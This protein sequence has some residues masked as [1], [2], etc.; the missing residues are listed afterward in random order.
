MAYNRRWRCLMALFATQAWM[1]LLSAV[2]NLWVGPCSTT[3]RLSP[4]CWLNSRHRSKEI[5]CLCCALTPEE[6]DAWLQQDAVVVAWLPLLTW[7]DRQL[8]TGLLNFKQDTDVRTHMDT[9]GWMDM[10]TFIIS[11]HQIFL[12]I[13]FNIFNNNVKIPNME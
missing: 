5:Y 9:N 11:K 10:H 13:L 8:R 2:P 4:L 1:Q 3:Q 6:R 7:A 12:I